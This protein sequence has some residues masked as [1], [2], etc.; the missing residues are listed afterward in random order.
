[1]NFDGIL[2]ISLIKANLKSPFR[3][4]VAIM[5]EWETENFVQS[6]FDPI[7]LQTFLLLLSPFSNLIPSFHDYFY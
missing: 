6:R 3:R 2:I 1:M 5:L 4:L 7:T